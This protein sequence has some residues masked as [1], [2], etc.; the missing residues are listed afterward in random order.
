MRSS[1]RYPLKEM[2]AGTLCRVDNLVG[3]GG[4]ATVYDVT[5]MSCGRKYAFKHLN[6][7]LRDRKDLRKQFVEEGIL[8]GRLHG[9]PNIVEV[10]TQGVTADEWELP[11][12]VMELLNGPNMRNVLAAQHHV[13]PM[14]ACALMGEVLAALEHA[15]ER[16]VVHRDVKPENVVSHRDLNGRPRIKLID[17]GIHRKGRHIG[18]QGVAGTPLYMAPELFEERSDAPPHL[19]DI[20]AAGVLLYELLTGATPFDTEPNDKEIAR[21]HKM[22]APAP[23][24]TFVDGLSVMVE[25]TT[26]RALEKDPSKRWPNAFEFM[27]ALR[28]CT[29]SHAQEQRQLNPHTRITAEEIPT[30]VGAPVDDDPADPNKR[31]DPGNPLGEEQGVRTDP[32]EPQ[33]GMGAEANSLT[34]PSVPWA[35]LQER[36]AKAMAHATRPDAPE[37]KIAAEATRREEIPPEEAPTSHGA[38]E[39]R[40]SR[41]ATQTRPELREV[42][43]EGRSG[44]PQVSL[45]PVRQDP[46]APE[47]M[48]QAVEQLEPETSKQPEEDEPDRIWVDQELVRAQLNKLAEVKDEGVIGRLVRRRRFEVRS[49]TVKGVLLPSAVFLTVVAIGFVCIRSLQ[50]T[51]LLVPITIAAE[52]GR[53]EP[54]VVRSKPEE[55]E[56]SFGVDGGRSLEVPASV[57]AMGTSTAPDRPASVVRTAPRTGDVRTRPS[58][59]VPR[60]SA[61]ADVFDKPF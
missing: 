5:E 52:H 44:T 24:S 8:L 19:A 27:E 31:T 40:H 53:N 45:P 50:R 15:H 33:D 18:R 4:M 28:L 59:S 48:Q 36:M 46:N 43:T 9:H 55:Q 32:G 60:D 54:V 34:E 20:Y 57:S 58:A 7:D 25:D 14:L 3:V 41:V 13:Q 22:K 35:V 17:F 21:A 23:P 42:A 51:E 29:Q 12:I 49:E 11:F 61:T 37:A 26:M 39:L 56:N 6:A 47:R 1:F 2:I 38:V 30:Q 10:F 16:D